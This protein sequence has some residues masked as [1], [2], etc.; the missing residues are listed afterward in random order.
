MQCIRRRYTSR[1]RLRL[2]LRHSKRKRERKRQRDKERERE[3]ETAHRYWGTNNWKKTSFPCAL[4]LWSGFVSLKC[5]ACT[6][7][8]ASKQIQTHNEKSKTHS[9]LTTMTYWWVYQFLCTFVTQQYFMFDCFLQTSC[10][11]HFNFFVFNDVALLR[12]V[13]FLSFPIPFRCFLLH[14]IA[15]TST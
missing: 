9:K 10:R 4:F 11:W 7:G 12:F 1:E 14:K 2:Q 15:V 6:H 8:I 5:N 13:R 3:K